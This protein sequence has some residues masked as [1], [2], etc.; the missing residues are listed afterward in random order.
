MKYILQLTHVTHA[1]SDPNFQSIPSLKDSLGSI[2][3]FSLLQPYRVPR[4]QALVGEGWKTN[5]L[6]IEVANDQ[7]LDRGE[8]S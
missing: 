5:P 1:T 6:L 8:S 7:L 2:G 3:E 4:L